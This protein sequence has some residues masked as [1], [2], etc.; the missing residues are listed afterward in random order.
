[1]P[2]SS[3]SGLVATLEARGY[4]TVGP[5]GV[6]L[7]AAYRDVGWVGGMTSSVVRSSRPVMKALSLQ[8]DESCFLGV[9]TEAMNIQFVEKSLPN[10]AIRYD[11]DSSIERPAYS[12]TA[13]MV[14]LAGLSEAELDEYFAMHELKALTVATMTDERTIRRA[15]KEVSSQ[16]YARL[17]DSSVI[18]ASGV[19]VPIFANGRVVAGLSIMAPR[20]RFLKSEQANI[21]AAVAAGKQITQALAYT[22]DKTRKAG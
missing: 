1:M 10:N 8:T 2:K 20:E 14:L 15:L 16:G 18:G 21:E 19:G 17:T 11:V 3:T 4:V 7:V 5:A 6:E 12:T 9:L 22:N 13:G